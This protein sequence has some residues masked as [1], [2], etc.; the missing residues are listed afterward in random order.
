[1]ECGLADT[2]ST[3]KPTNRRNKIEILKFKGRA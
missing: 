3:R 2:F 1:M